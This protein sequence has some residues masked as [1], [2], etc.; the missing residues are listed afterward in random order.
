MKTH[1]QQ[2]VTKR[3]ADK[4]IT[5][6]AIQKL[7]GI[8]EGTIRNIINGKAPNPTL[9]VLLSLTSIFDCSLSELV[10]DEHNQIESELDKFYIRLDLDYVLLEQVARIVIDYVKSLDDPI[11]YSHINKGIMVLY[12]YCET[13]KYCE[14]PQDFCRWYLTNAFMS[15]P[16]KDKS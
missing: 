10:G 1:L 13:N 15:E 4:N 8:N 9:N 3:L 14:P 16:E 11:S 5:P 12:Q 6:Y 7:T 2:E